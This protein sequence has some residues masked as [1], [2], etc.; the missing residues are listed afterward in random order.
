MPPATTRHHV[1]TGCRT[2]KC[3]TMAPA[4]YSV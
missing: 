2:C 3:V 4:S 1:K